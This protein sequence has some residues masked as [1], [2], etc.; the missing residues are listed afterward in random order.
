MHTTLSVCDNLKSLTYQ[1]NSAVATILVRRGSLKIGSHIISGTSVAKVRVMTDSSGKTVKSA[2]PGMAVTVSGWKTLPKAGDDVLQGTEADIKKAIL[3]RQRKVD[4]EASLVDVE[5]INTSR[6]EERERRELGAE[7]VTAE[8]EEDSGPKE[9]KLV[10]KA[11]VSGSAEAVVGALQG[12][13]NH[14]ATTKVIASSVGDVT[15]S[16]VTLAKTAGGEHAQCP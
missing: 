15:E 9:L 3:N 8:T 6:R 13:G 2:S 11:D 1:F 12:M 16:D 7:G 14:L 5:A 4:L 10:V